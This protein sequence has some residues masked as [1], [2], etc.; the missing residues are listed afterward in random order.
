MSDGGEDDNNNNNLHYVKFTVQ[1]DADTID[2]FIV[3]VHNDWAPLGAARFLEL[4][5]TTTNTTT[6]TT[7]SPQPFFA[8]VRFFRVLSDFVSQFGISGDPA[9]NAYWQNKTL[10]DDP[11]VSSNVRG[12]VTF[13][14]GGPNTRTTQIFINS[15]DDNTQLDDM[16]FAPFA[17]VVLSGMQVVDKLYAGYGEGVPMGNGP[18]QSRIQ[19]EGNAYLEQDFPLL[20]YILSAE[21][22]SPPAELMETTTTTTTTT[23]EPANSDNSESQQQQEQ[24]QATTQPSSS[25]GTGTGSQATTRPTTTSG[26]SE[27]QS[28]QPGSAAS[29]FVRKGLC[30]LFSIA[31][32]MG[33]QAA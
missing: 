2:S 32:A 25:S 20:S 7:S 18:D 11:V 15:N 8:Q 27:S 29:S 13:A 31:V 9:V 4:V 6:N 10:P 33:I 28:S 21:R 3:E 19:N 24:Q 23:T 14:T 5:D 16:G 12:T 22:I 17:K 26:S 30:L 1:L